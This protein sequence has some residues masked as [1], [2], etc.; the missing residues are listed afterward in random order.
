MLRHP[1]ILGDPN[2]RR[3]EQN[4]KW[5]PTKG[6]KIKSGCVNP[7]FSGANKRAEMLRH[8]C[9]LGDPQRQARGANQKWSI[10]KGNKIKS[11]YCTLAFSGAQKRA[12]NSIAFGSAPRREVDSQPISP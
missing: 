9:I 5:S 2:T 10:T 8:P 7:A 12:E 3:G 11:V 6:N 1:C 4:Q